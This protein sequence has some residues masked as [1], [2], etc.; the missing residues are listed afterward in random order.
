MNMRGGICEKC[1]R[2]VV[3]SDPVGYFVKP[4]DTI[5]QAELE[6]IER[7]AFRCT[8]L[9]RIMY[10]RVVERIGPGK[11][12]DVGCGQGYLFLELSSRHSDLHGLD[13][14]K[15]DIQR[16]QKWVERASFCVA[17]AQNIPY[18]SNIFDYLVCTEVLEH[19]PPEMGNNVVKECYR[20]LK[21]QG[22]AIFSVP[23]GNGIAGKIDVHHI[24]FFTFC[25]ITSLFKEAGFEV[26]H[27]K[28]VGF[29]IPFVGR[30]IELL[31]GTTGNRLPIIPFLDIEV[32]E[33]LSISFFIE[34]RKPPS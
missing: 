30:F 3:L 13:L 1:H 21:P 34:C 16:A 6:R 33:S 9:R 2:E 26:V 7:V 24:R 28:K 12:L 15:F 5:R 14:G 31:N 22:I 27:G 20:V 29:Y 8:R 11:V 32:P 4:D 18:K 19:L 25:S 17:D 10:R 23:N